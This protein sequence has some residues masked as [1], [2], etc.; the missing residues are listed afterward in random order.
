MNDILIN[1]AKAFYLN[2]GVVTISDEIY[3][4]LLVESG[5]TKDE[6]FNIIGLERSKDHGFPMNLK[7]IPKITVND[8][9]DFRINPNS[10]GNFKYDGGSLT[11]YYENG[12]LKGI[13]SA[14]GILQ[15]KKLINHFP[16]RVNP[17]VSRIYAEGVV[18]I[19]KYGETARQYANG[20][21]NS[22]HKQNEV[23]ENFKIIAFDVELH[24]G[25]SDRLNLLKS[26]PESDRFVVTEFVERIPSGIRNLIALNRLYIPKLSIEVYIDG[27]VYYDRTDSSLDRIYKLYMNELV[28]STVRKLDVIYQPHSDMSSVKLIIDQVRIDGTNVGKIAASAANV[29]RKKL[30]VGARI[31]VFKSGQTIPKEKDV[32]EGSTDFTDLKC[33]CGNPFTINDAVGN[34]FKCS[35]YQCSTRKKSLVENL[36]RLGG[37]N[38]IDDLIQV[39]RLP[40][41][42]KDRFSNEFD[43]SEFLKIEDYD[44]YESYFRSHIKLTNTQ[45][46]LLKFNLKSLFDEK[47]KYQN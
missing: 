17:D 33:S 20:F 8:Y 39:L 19:N 13:V 2:K 43:L 41:F 14:S 7:E 38:N 15:T 37:I 36:S 32:I 42:G 24:S 27:L 29:F 26:L 30:G 4:K 47:R 5:L 28:E 21:I 10:Y 25:G 1:N 18:D 22:V 40:S 31:S 45:S 23:D 11:A 34:N 9:N 35:D 46:N 16:N 6:L 12:I 3:D 44:Q